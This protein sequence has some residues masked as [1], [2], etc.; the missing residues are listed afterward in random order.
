MGQGVSAIF[1]SSGIFDKKRGERENGEYEELENEIQFKVKEKEKER[2][3]EE[4]EIE[5]RR[6]IERNRQIRKE[7]KKER[8]REAQR[9]INIPW[10]RHTN[11]DTGVDQYINDIDAVLNTSAH[12]KIVKSMVLYRSCE[13]EKENERERVESWND[14]IEISRLK[15]IELESTTWNFL[16]VLSICNMSDSFSESLLHSSS[17]PDAL[18]LACPNLQ[19]LEIVACSGLATLTSHML[20][21]PPNLVDLVITHCDMVLFELELPVNTLSLLDISSNRLRSIPACLEMFENWQM[22][23]NKRVL[24]G[25]VGCPRL[26]LNGNDFWFTEGSDVSYPKVN[27]LTLPELTR[28]AALGLIGSCT[29]SKAIDHVYPERARE[30]DI[31]R[32]RTRGGNAVVRK[33]AT[34]YDNSQSVHISSVQSGVRKVIQHLKELR[35][36]NK[37]NPNAIKEFSAKLNEMKRGSGSVLRVWCAEMTELHGT[38]QMSM[39]AICEA[40]FIAIEAI[41]IEEPKGEKEKDAMT[42]EQKREKIKDMKR[43]AYKSIAYE[44][45]KNKKVCFT[46]RITHLLGALGGLVPGFEITVSLNEEIQNTM[47]F[48]RNKWVDRLGDDLNAYLTE[49][50]PEATQALCDL[51]VPEG[52]MWSWLDAL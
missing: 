42:P 51:C 13:E 41:H 49:A 32:E 30:R 23:A 29:L 27:E 43:E 34:T 39:T 5:R 47:A 19:R 18:A 31:A 6:E 7:R 33:V 36:T 28:A 48:I 11:E 40:V 15:S 4:E 26:I 24:R 46:G 17:E 10:I 35:A 2:N 44:I 12:L 1:D 37:F 45:H 16:R 3:N 14:A 21:L 38:Y 8:K 20:T 25:I 9:N 22:Q 52:D 50:V